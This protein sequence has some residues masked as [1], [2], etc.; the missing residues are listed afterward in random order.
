LVHSVHSFSFI[1]DYD[2]S[3]PSASICIVPAT[4]SWMHLYRADERPARVCPSMHG[5]DEHFGRRGAAC[6]GTTTPPFVVGCS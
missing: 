5:A 3:H 1:S 4:P 2:R 6:S